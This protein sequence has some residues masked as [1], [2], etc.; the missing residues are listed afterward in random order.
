MATNKTVP[1]KIS[2]EDFINT[3][4]DERKKEDSFRLIRIMEKL[5]GEKATMWGPSI[6]GFGTYHYKYASGHEGDMCRIG[7]SPRKSEFS[8]YL[9][10]DVNEFENLL[11]RFG[12]HKTGKGCIYFKRLEDIDLK[13]LEEMI[14]TSLKQTKAMYG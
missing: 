4:P 11:Q 3:L 2:V 6:V 9:T 7:F 12:K 5:S 13:V 8:L 10:C 1:T 14:K